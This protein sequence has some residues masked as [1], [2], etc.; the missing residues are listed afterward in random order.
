VVKF[1][2]LSRNCEGFWVLSSEPQRSGGFYRA[3]VSRLYPV[4]G[5]GRRG[6]HDRDC[7][8]GLA[9]AQNVEL[10]NNSEPGSDDGVALRCR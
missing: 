4:G 2:T 6:G 5:A 3:G 7:G 9:S 8:A 10:C 1:R